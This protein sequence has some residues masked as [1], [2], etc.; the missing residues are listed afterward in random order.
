MRALASIPVRSRHRIFGA[1]NAVS[2]VTRQF[3]DDDLYVLHSIGEQMGVAIERA[4]VLEQLRRGREN[5]QRLARYCLVAQEE[6]RRRISRELHDETSQSISALALSLRAL[7][8][9]AEAS[10]Q[11][12]ES[13]E[14]I[15]KVESLAQQ[16]AYELTRIINDLRPGLLDSAGLVPAIRRFAQEHMQLQEVDVSVEVRGHI[17][18]LAPEVESNLFRF[19]Q[20]AVSNVARH[21]EARTLK[22]AID[23]GEDQLTLRL[24]DDGRGFDISKITN[25]DEKTGRGRGL[26]A[27]KERI[28]LLGGSCKVESVPGQAR[29]SWRKY[30]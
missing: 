4:E 29:R 30:L 12:K 22:I 23:C 10:G 15:K 5:Y 27:M 14:R 11:S 7:V 1:I 24:R 9:M 8:E 2:E 19:V 20:G 16:T 21:A 18:R 26:F 28:R 6:E 13:I 3:S 17:P 25:I